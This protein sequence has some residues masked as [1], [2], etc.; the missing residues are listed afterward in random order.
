VK[1]KYMKSIYLFGSRKETEPWQAIA[2][3]FTG[4]SA[5]I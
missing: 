3:V 5:D 2:L 4:T 1:H